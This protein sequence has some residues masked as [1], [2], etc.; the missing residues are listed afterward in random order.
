MKSVHPSAPPPPAIPAVFSDVLASDL[1]DDPTRSPSVEK[2]SAKATATRRRRWGREAALAA[3]V[4]GGLGG[5][6]ALARTVRGV[7]AGTRVDDRVVRALGRLRGP[8]TN[9]I[10]RGLTELGGVKLVTTFALA[11]IGAS[12]STP[13][14]AAQ[15]AVGACGGVAAEL[16]LKRFF[17][18]KRPTELAHLERVTSTSFPSGHAMAAASFYLTLAFVGSRH[19]RLRGARGVLLTSAA[20]VATTIAATRVYLGVHWPTD[21]LAGLA[22]GTAWAC[23]SEAAFDL[24]GAEKLEREAQAA[25]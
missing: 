8:V 7:D 25:A 22:L 23:G 21:V 13:R 9:R 24:T 19:R 4:L 20:L 6:A 17:R 11:A 14:L 2:A 16:G 15:V 3:V 10:V 12:R 1:V 5:F 18:R